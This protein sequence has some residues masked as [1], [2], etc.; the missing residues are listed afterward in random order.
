MNNNLQK[1]TAMLDIMRKRL[2]GHEP[3]QGVNERHYLSDPTP[4]A[5]A[6]YLATLELQIPEVAVFDANSGIIAVQDA[7]RRKNRGRGAMEP[8]VLEDQGLIPKSA[9]AARSF[10]RPTQRNLRVHKS[11]P[12][13]GF[14]GH[15][16]G[17]RRLCA[18]VSCQ[19]G[20]QEG[21]TWNSFKNEPW[22]ICSLWQA[23]AVSKTT[24]AP[25]VPVLLSCRSSEGQQ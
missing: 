2:M 9:L 21:K 20:M 12:E 17:Q 4:D 14:S 5:M 23:Q 18:C 1:R 11:D 6:P 10:T 15:L 3:G 24:S 7:L 22:Q 25:T 16:C 19:Q 8:W 13:G